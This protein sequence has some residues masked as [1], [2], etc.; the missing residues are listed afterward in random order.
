MERYN[1]LVMLI[2]AA[3]LGG[4]ICFFLLVKIMPYLEKKEASSQRNDLLEE[5]KK[6]KKHILFTHQEQVQEN[7]NLLEEELEEAIKERESEQHSEGKSLEDQEGD[8][9]KKEEALVELEESLEEKR[10]AAAATARS[11]LAQKKSLEDLTVRIVEELSKKAHV[12]HS[13]QQRR[14]AE[15]IISERRLD[16]QRTL[17][18]LVEDLN[19]SSHKKALR[20]LDRSLNRYAPC[21]VWPK[22]LNIV[23]IEKEAVFAKM[24]DPSCSVLEDLRE[25][26]QVTIQELPSESNSS[27]GSIKVVG[28]YGIS[29]ESARLA[30]ED[31]KTMDTRHWGRAV[32]V[33][34]KHFKRLEQE[35][36][37]LGKKAVDQLQLQNIHPEIQKLVGALNWR[38]SYR[39]NQWYHTVEVATLAGMLARELGVNAEDAK[40]VGLLHDIGKVLDY[41]IEGSHAVISGDYAD[42]YGEERYICDTVMSHHADLI[43]ETPLAYI[44]CAADTLSGARPGARVNLEEGYQIRLSA[45]HE[46]VGSFSGIHDV[47]IMNGGREVH[48]QVDPKAVKEH[49]VG[50]LTKA[51]AKKIEEGVAYPGQIKVIIIRTYESVAVA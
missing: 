45:M 33:Y 47:A 5:A 19:A 38:T 1:L 15:E 12:D 24:C 23:D 51:I 41:R 9:L 22:P 25:C 27:I 21:F 34:E 4:F 32:T 14:F 49:E 35:A 39:Q 42:R 18:L 43:V 26:S 6:Q 11:I 50:P 20:F 31:L 29:K 8:Y 16:S 48:I 2:L 44:L 36:Y 10:S 28:G 37:V 46:A 40:R 30:L 3:S 13:R 17:R 7:I